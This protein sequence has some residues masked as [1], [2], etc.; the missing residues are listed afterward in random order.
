MNQAG[1]HAA[2][3][4]TDIGNRNTIFTDCN[5]HPEH[6]TPDSHGGVGRIHFV[7]GAVTEF[8]FQPVG[9]RTGLQMED[10][11]AV[12]TAAGSF[13]AHNRT[14][15]HQGILVLIHFHFQPAFLTD[16]DLVTG[17]QTHTLIRIHGTHGFTL[18]ADGAGYLQNLNHPVGFLLLPCTAAK[19]EQ[20]H[21]HQT[22]CHQSI[23][24]HD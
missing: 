15:L 1:S 19:A 12:G 13:Q 5:F 3:V 20:Q 18:Y 17:F 24:F 9:N 4:N 14:R 11:L 7:A 21:Q 23:L 8:T 10:S 2:A 6:G 16:R 22:E